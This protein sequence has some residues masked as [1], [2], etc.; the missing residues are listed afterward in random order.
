MAILLEA[1]VIFGSP[2]IEISSYEDYQHKLRSGEHPNE[3]QGE[4]ELIEKELERHAREEGCEVDEDP[5]LLEVTG[6]VEPFGY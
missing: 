2:E 3:L 1:T 6:L 4:K 5:G